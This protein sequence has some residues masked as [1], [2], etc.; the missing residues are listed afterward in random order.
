MP[1][2]LYHGLSRSDCVLIC[3]T[4]CFVLCDSIPASL[5]ASVA[6]LVEHLPGKREVVGLNP[7]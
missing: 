6:Q 1:E 5:A 2:T 7:T 3:L 4:N